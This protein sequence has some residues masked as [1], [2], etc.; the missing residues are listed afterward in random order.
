MIGEMT[1][2]VMKLTYRQLKFAP[3]TGRRG[4]Q[5][6]L[7]AFTRILGFCGP[8]L[9]QVSLLQ[10]V[11][12]QTP[13]RHLQ[14]LLHRSATKFHKVSVCVRFFQPGVLGVMT[15]SHVQDFMKTLTVGY[16]SPLFSHQH[17][18][19]FVS[20]AQ[21]IGILIRIQ[22]LISKTR[23]KHLHFRQLPRLTASRPL[24]HEETSN[25]VTS[26]SG[27]RTNLRPLYNF[28]FVFSLTSL[29]LHRHGHHNAQE[30]RNQQTVGQ[31]SLS[32][33]AA[34]E[35]PSRVSKSHPVSLEIRTVLPPSN[36]RFR[37][38]P[39]LYVRLHL[40]SADQSRL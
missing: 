3:L 7:I 34:L 31:L 37:S 39:D 16:E 17:S 40:S 9:C 24:P 29:S 11:L 22:Q 25:C 8:S 13:S 6:C 23:L 36:S 14:N 10:N 32:R 28:W 5:Y 2:V 30:T 4:G 35:R 21:F 26:F 38:Q 12:Y 27:A 19:R 20:H 15:T 33:P 18:C 1:T